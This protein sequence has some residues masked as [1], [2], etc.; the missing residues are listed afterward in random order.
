[1]K[2]MLVMFAMVMAALVANA[3]SFNWSAANIYGADGAK[4]TGTATLYCAELDGWSATTA[5]NSGS[6]LKTAADAQFSS[7]NFVAGTSY[8]FYYVI[9]SNGATF[10]S[11][12]VVKAAQATATT[13]IAFGNQATATQNA[14]NWKGGGGDAPEP[15]SGLL[16]LIGGAM[17][18]LRRKQK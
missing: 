6:I 4:F 10:T 9:E 18:A 7:E 1:M 16:L 11:A 8:S 17:L 12:Q 3:A 14:D 13:T 5:V 2:K 15:T